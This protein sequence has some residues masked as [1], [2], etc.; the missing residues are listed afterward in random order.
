MV[1]R[2]GRSH[3]FTINKSF[4]LY[5]LIKTFFF[6]QGGEVLLSNW[7]TGAQQQL[8]WC[9]HTHHVLFL[10]YA[11]VC[12]LVRGKPNNAGINTRSVCWN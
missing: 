2:S 7:K 4:S 5:S 8:G 12:F 10:P 3:Y 6:Q 9:L 1:R 11:A